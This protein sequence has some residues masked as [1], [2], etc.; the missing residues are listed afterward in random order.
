ML[1]KYNISEGEEFMEEE[2]SVKDRKIRKKALIMTAIF[3]IVI[4]IIEAVIA[5]AIALIWENRNNFEVDVI[6]LCM[7]ITFSDVV[8]VI[9]AYFDFKKEITEKE[10]SKED[11]T[12]Q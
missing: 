4:V 8:L 2:S 7:G 3:T 12:I 10:K 6:S 11:T 9:L 5:V 1:G